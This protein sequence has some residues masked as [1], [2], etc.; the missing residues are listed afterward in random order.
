MLCGEGEKSAIKTVNIFTAIIIVEL[1]NWTEREKA[2]V[3]DAA[4]QLLLESQDARS[5]V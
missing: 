1:V 3:H 5:S 2:N 4:A